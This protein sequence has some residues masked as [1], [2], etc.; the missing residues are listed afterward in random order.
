MVEVHI[1]GIDT[2][3]HQRINLVRRILIGSRDPRVTETTSVEN[4][5]IRGF[6]QSR[7][8]S[9]GRHGSVAAGTT[10][11]S[12]ISVHARARV[13]GTR[14]R[15]QEKEHASATLGAAPDA[16]AAPQQSVDLRLT[17][18]RTRQAYSKVK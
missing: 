17:V 7:C 8:R 1:V 3:A 2:G 5:L 11:V 13:F 18:D 15:R 14:P 16:S 12:L 9:S 4:T 6:R 10:K